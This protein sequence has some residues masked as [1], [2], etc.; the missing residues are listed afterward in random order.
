MVLCRHE[1]LARNIKNGNKE[2]E[3]EPKKEKEK[4]K[5][6]LRQKNNKLQLEETWFQSKISQ[7]PV[8]KYVVN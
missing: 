1:I 3:K 4:E 7:K 2:K 5:K 6:N 8:W